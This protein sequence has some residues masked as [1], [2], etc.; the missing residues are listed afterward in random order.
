MS[1]TL[2]KPVHANSARF[3]AQ[4]RMSPTWALIWKQCADLTQ[5]FIV[6]LAGSLLVL[7]VLA[8]ATRN[9]SF[10]FGWTLVSAAMFSVGFALVA[11]FVSFVTE[12][13]SQTREFLGNLPVTS[14]HVGAIKLSMAVLAVFVFFACQILMAFVAVWLRDKLGDD[15]I[16]FAGSEY[17]SENW[18]VIAIVV[19]VVFVSCSISCSFWASSWMSVF[20]AAF[21]VWG[22]T[23]TCAWLGC[24]PSM[25][26]VDG[27][28]KIYPVF[29][30]A[31]LLTASILA[32]GLPLV[33]LRRR[34]LLGRRRVANGPMD[35][36]EEDDFW[37]TLP[38]K[39][40]IKTP[41]CLSMPSRGR[42]PALCWQ[43]VRQQGVVPL[44]AVVALG[45]LVCLFGGVVDAKVSSEWALEQM[46]FGLTLVLMF[47]GYGFGWATVY[48]DKLNSNFSFF[49]QHQEHGRELLMAR[50]LFPLIVLWGTAM[51]GALGIYC[52]Y[53]SSID[54]WLP[55]L[56]GLGAYSV[57]LM[58]SMAFRSH[59]YAL[60]V[61][62][63]IALTFNVYVITWIQPSGGDQ[64]WMVV[65]P[66][67]WLATCF[68]C[69]PA[70]LSGR[71][72]AAWMTW[73]TLV[74]IATFF[75]PLWMLIRWLV[76][77]EP[78][79]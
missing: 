28:V 53:G 55:L 15:S 17:V 10:H 7:L 29:P 42:F 8:W 11:C 31:V 56:S 63:V 71:I 60:G 21:L 24:F 4:K 68:A 25:E 79:A 38:S 62:F 13:E 18:S 43:S 9:Q 33:W 6:L 37:G 46:V 76:G 70:W 12:S 1:N 61:G 49:Q 51:A 34:P 52:F 26:M 39:F 57:T 14:F 19:A 65:L 77:M 50:V 45:L 32:I 74:S 30:T 67:V 5:S 27:S 59:V 35:H 20:C 64:Q 16:W 66:F 72:G 36:F 22:L 41:A 23:V 78:R 73:F 48:R 75:V 69:A 58:W 3:D 2:L 47:A 40:G 44:L 54:I